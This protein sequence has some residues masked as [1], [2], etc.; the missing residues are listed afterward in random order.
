[1]EANAT[2][3][4]LAS[5]TEFQVADVEPEMDDTAMQ[6]E[7]LRR[8]ADLSGGKCL[9]TLEVSELPSLLKL[10]PYSTTFTTEVP[11][12]DNG[13]LALVLVTLMGLEWLVRRRYDLP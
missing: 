10:E 5:A 13:W 7:H 8:I 3:R 4:S 1:M 9:S 12:W 11:L 6:L 2:D